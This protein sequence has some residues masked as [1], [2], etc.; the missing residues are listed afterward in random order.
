MKQRFSPMIH[1]VAR[2]RNETLDCDDSCAFLLHRIG[3][4]YDLLIRHRSGELDCQITV[5]I[6]N[7]DKL[8]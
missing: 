4:L 2:H 6:S 3:S 1:R 5:V 8:R 7:H